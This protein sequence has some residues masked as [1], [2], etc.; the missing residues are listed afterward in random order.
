MLKLTK[1]FPKELTNILPLDVCKFIIEPYLNPWRDNF[2]ICLWELN[3]R[4]NEFEIT[5]NNNMY[6]CH[7][8]NIKNLLK[9]WSLHRDYL[10]FK[11]LKTPFFKS[12]LHEHDRPQ[13]LTRER[14]ILLYQFSHIMR[15]NGKICPY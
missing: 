15:I 12:K 1:S 6:G 13:F 2:N 7:P 8:D 9:R 10:F 4:F 11:Y 3:I 5:Y 14:C